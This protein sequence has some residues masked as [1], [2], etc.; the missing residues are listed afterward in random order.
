[1]FLAPRLRILC[2][3]I[4]NLHIELVAT[5]RAFSLTKREADIAFSLNRPTQSRIISRKLT[6]YDLG[7]YASKSY[8]AEPDP[9]WARK[10]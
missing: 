3:Q 4:P 1:M 5:A 10:T 8:L 9:F 7:L 2:D 6:D